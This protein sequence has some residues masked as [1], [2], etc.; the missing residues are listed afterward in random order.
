MCGIAGI[1]GPDAVP[2]QLV[3]RMLKAI[4]Y[5]GP[6]HLQVNTFSDAKGRFLTVGQ[7]RLSIM[8][9]R[10][11]ANQPFEN[12]AKD[13]SITFNGEFYNFLDIREQVES[14][15]S[16]RTRSDTEVAL[17]LMDTGPLDH[18]LNRLNGM[19]AGCYHRSSDGTF[20]LFRDRHG[21]KPLY[22]YQHA[23]L[24]YFASEPK[25]ILAALDHVPEI[26][27][28][29]VSYFFYLSYVPDFSCIY[30]GM[31]RLAPGHMLTM[32]PQGQVQTKQWYRPETLE[33]QGEDQLEALFFDAVRQ[34]LIAD[35]PL[36]AFLSGGLD[37]SLVV[38]AMAQLSS[39]RMST[40]SVRFAGPQA[41]D[42]SP[43]ARMVAEHCQTDHHEIVLDHTKLRD[44]IPQ[45]LD[46]FD[47]PFGDSSAIPMFLVSQ[48]ARRQFTVALSGDGAD[49]VFAGYRKY[50]GE[51]YIS[52]LGPYI[53]RRLFW[54]P[55][56]K[57]LPTGRTN[58]AL[59][60]NRRMRRLLMGDAPSSAE[61]HIRWLKMSPIDEQPLLGP[62]LMHHSF[63]AVRQHLLT[64][65]PEAADLND[66]LRF[67]Q[68]LVLQGQM[69]VKVDRMSM[70]AS[71]E[72][73]CPMV[74]YRLVHLANQLPVQ[75]KLDGTLRK[76][77]LVKRLGHLLPKE[78]L[79]RPKAGFEMPL[80]AWLRND[81]RD[82]AAHTLFETPSPEG[83]VNRKML[84]KIWQMHVQGR[85]DCTETLWCHLVFHTWW[86]RTYA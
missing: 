55:I 39:K 47:E 63:E 51:H 45:V 11:E 23:G 50:L 33:F 24:L 81:L 7:V 18:A 74:D 10:P 66:C 77:V 4:G 56:S 40:F 86:Q 30:K 58:K 52:K 27:R 57:L 26:D 73:R 35:V 34:R 62:E 17:H 79:E 29:A 54:N 9:P 64:M 72:V 6:D 82:W 84:K 19:F 25:A 21:K 59:E 2:K 85:L 83:F 8:D 46:H 3:E 1:Y 12:A 71:L 37:S 68:N 20:W 5:R 31:R 49:E 75:A 41:F 38:A 22:Y 14:K 15:T 43:F 69:F 44:M 53:A 32:D 70:K 16:F 61:R 28:A 60:M 80:G 76:A 13:A 65:L 67:D 36:A 48:E 42:E 78:V